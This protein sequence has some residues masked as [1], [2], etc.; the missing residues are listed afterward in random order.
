[1][2]T[3]RERSSKILTIQQG[4]PREVSSIRNARQA[5]TMFSSDLRKASGF[6]I[7]HCGTGWTSLAC[8]NCS[9][10]KTFQVAW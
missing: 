6:V 2:H 9:L 3:S 4:Q 7:H 10:Y 1:M 5:S 8:A